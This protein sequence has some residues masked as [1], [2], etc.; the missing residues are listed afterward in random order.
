MSRWLE[1]SVLFPRPLIANIILS[2]VAIFSFRA[3]GSGRSMDNK[4]RL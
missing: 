2:S 1:L 4:K 3:I